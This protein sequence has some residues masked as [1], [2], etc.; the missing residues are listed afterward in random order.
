MF[1]S[2]GPHY[3]DDDYRHDQPYL[4][5]TELRSLQTERTFTA[6]DGLVRFGC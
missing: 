6:F 1:H 2:V 3:F 4:Y 5:A